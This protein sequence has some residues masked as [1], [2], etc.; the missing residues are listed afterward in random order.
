[1]CASSQAGMVLPAPIPIPA[2]A[3][4]G[5]CCCYPTPSLYSGTMCASSQAGMVLPAPVP[6][7]AAARTGLVW[8]T[9]LAGFLP[10]AWTRLFVFSFTTQLQPLPQHNHVAYHFNN[11]TQ[12]QG[13]T[14]LYTTTRKSPQ[15]L[16]RQLSKHYIRQ[17][18]TRTLYAFPASFHPL[19]GQHAPNTKHSA[20]QRCWLARL[21]STTHFSKQYSD[22]LS[23]DS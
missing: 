15:R 18:T 1:M 11:T 14:A 10:L 8:T 21:H 3:R 12:E 16:P 7:P 22:A 13:I 17:N 20:T 9:S 6:Y 4:L 2:A 5:L 19:E 23:A